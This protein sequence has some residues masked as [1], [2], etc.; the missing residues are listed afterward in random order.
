MP[1]E[2]R[3][4]SLAAARWLERLA[5]DP[6]ASRP[7]GIG[8]MFDRAL[9]RLKAQDGSGPIPVVGAALAK[10]GVSFESAD[11]VT[12]AIHAMGLTA[13][14]GKRSSDEAYEL[15]H[16]VRGESPFCENLPSTLVSAHAISCA[17]RAAAARLGAWA[18]GLDRA[19]YSA[20]VADM[21]G[22]E[23]VDSYL[24]AAEDLI[25]VLT[26]VD[27]HDADICCISTGS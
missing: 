24:A 17:P 23:A 5:S 12:S 2:I 26:S 25:G 21:Y 20:E 22:T 13:A 14:I 11:F 9:T 1:I 6:A 15:E 4:C 27:T 18:R 8:R 3:L 7:T 16:F 10:G 19:I